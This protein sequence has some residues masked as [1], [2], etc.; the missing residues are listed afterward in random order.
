MEG[1]PNIPSYLATPR[2]YSSLGRVFSYVDVRDAT[3][4]KKTTYVPI[5]FLA[6]RVAVQLFWLLKNFLKVGILLK[7]REYSNSVTVVPP[8]D[9]LILLIFCF[10][11]YYSITVLCFLVIKGCLVIFWR[12]EVF[13]N[14]SHIL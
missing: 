12:V 10:P 8:A 14:Y 6:N 11:S 13:G 4:N 5:V 7:K 2:S 3:H 1:L 9:H